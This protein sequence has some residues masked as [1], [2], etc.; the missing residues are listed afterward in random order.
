MAGHQA[1]GQMLGYLYQ[2]RY[3]LMLLLESNNPDEQISIEKYDDVAFDDSGTPTERIQ[4]K[5]HISREG[6]LTN[7][8]IDLW[9]T[10]KVWIDAVTT[11]PSI[12][13]ITQFAIVTTAIAPDGSIANEM[14]Q[15]PV[16]DVDDLYYRLKQVCLSSKSTTNKP[17][18]EAFL[19]AD[20]DIILML[21]ENVQVIDKAS[22]FINCE[23]RIRKSIR[24]SCN[25]QYEDRVLERVEGFWDR[26][27]VDAL[28]SDDPIFLSN[29]QIRSKVVEISQEYHDDNLPIDI[30]DELIASFEAASDHNDIFFQ[31]LKL[32]GCRSRT[33]QKALRDYYSAYEQRASWIRNGY[34]YGDELDDY[35]KRLI[36]EWERCFA[37]MEDE[38]DEDSPETEKRKAGRNLKTKIEDQDLRIRDRCGEPFIMRGSYHM[39]ADELKVGWHVDFYER[40]KHLLGE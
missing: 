7:S 14:R 24:Y 4:L 10:L 5:H 30:D 28:M 2:V 27:V 36:D 11:N 34:L 29:N 6:D 1:P 17:Y 32:I 40:L 23:S 13:S 35:E 15:N 25:P 16:N 20:Q 9:R 18:Y 3:A 12:A 31:Q 8:S 22:D 26:I 38:I 37:A 39:L 33:L 21:L 19:K